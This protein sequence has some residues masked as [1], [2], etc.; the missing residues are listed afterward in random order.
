MLTGRRG[1]PLDGCAVASALAVEHP[2][3]VQALVAVD[4][5]YLVGDATVD[6]VPELMAAMDT[7]LES[8]SSSPDGAGLPLAPGARGTS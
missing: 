5:G 8:I 4:P 7:W 6:G 2:E 3:M 1:G